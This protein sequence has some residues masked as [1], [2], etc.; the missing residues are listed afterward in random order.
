MSISDALNWR[1]ATKRMNGEKVPADT[2]NRIL[3]AARLAPSSFGLQ[4]Y[5]V[6]VIGDDALR[7]RVHAAA[8]DQPQVLEA[9]HLLVFAAWDNLDDTHVDALIRLTAEERGM[10]PGDM[11]AYANSIK[12]TING[13]ASPGEVFHWAAKQAYLSLGTSLV[14]AAAE[15][16]DATPMEG[17]DAAA[18][19]RVLGFGDRGLRS[20]VLMAVGYRDPETDWLATLPKVRWPSEEVIVRY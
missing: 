1:Y 9:S 16:V 12:S 15:R 19:D 3:E 8:C 10:D 7:E 13:F 4:P 14:A 20:V 2:M 18:L 17:F 6:V 5:S 11:A